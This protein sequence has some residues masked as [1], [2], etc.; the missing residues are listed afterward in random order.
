MIVEGVSVMLERNLSTY[1]HLEGGS[2][3]NAEVQ[4]IGFWCRDTEGNLSV[5]FV[6][7]WEEICV[8]HMKKHAVG[9]H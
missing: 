8:S 6:D 7:F 9:V 1:V 4:I 5:H 2:L 3:P